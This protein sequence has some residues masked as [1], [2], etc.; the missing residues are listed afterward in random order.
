[1]SVSPGIFEVLVVMGRPLALR[2]LDN[3]LRW[4]DGRSEA[5]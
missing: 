4:L 3:A 2:R 5:A 1:M